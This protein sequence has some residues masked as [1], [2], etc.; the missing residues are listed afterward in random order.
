MFLS[1]FLAVY[2]YITLFNE[3]KK[4]RNICMGKTYFEIAFHKD[5]KMP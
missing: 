5:K 2:L 1:F 3:K 4:Y